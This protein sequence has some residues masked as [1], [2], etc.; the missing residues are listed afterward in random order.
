MRWVS[1]SAST[2]LSIASKS[3]AVVGGKVAA[4]AS[5]WVKYMTATINPVKRTAV[6]THL[7]GLIHHKEIDF[8]SFIIPLYI[9]VFL[10]LILT[11]SPGWSLTVPED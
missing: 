4:L 6:A 11:S 5:G 8:L 9:S 3:G 7:A 2:N 1:I 10:R